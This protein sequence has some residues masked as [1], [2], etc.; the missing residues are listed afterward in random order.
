MHDWKWWGLF[1]LG[2]FLGN[3]IIDFVKA[4][5]RNRD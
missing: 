1:V 4:L 3:V 2:M 5:W